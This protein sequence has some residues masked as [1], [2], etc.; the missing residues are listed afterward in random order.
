MEEKSGEET[1]PTQSAPTAKK[2]WF[3]IWK[4]IALTLLVI[5][6]LGVGYYYSVNSKTAYAPSN[7]SNYSVSPSPSATQA[8]QTETL[9]TYS[10]TKYGYSFEYPSGWQVLGTTSDDNIGLAPM[11][12]KTAAIRV[13]VS[14]MVFDDQGVIPF[15][16]YVKV[17]AKNEIQNYTK[18]STIKAVTTTSGVVGYETTWNVAPPPGAGGSVSTSD[19]MVY[20]P[21]SAKYGTGLLSKRLQVSTE[22]SY[23]TYADIFQALLPTFKFSN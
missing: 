13:D 20:F 8:A 17:A 18:L 3:N 4:V 19:P 2:S 22:G 6:L 12:G 1:K 16:D 7:T 10:N 11:G 14:T 9:K 5:V 23:A 21:I 15:S